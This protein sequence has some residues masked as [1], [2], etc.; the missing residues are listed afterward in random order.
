MKK[1]KKEEAG[2]QIGPNP[3]NPNLKQTIPS[4]VRNTPRSASLTGGI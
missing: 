4:R 1:T 3:Y 2:D